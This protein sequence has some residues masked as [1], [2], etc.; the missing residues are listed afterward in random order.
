MSNKTSPWDA[1]W[2]ISSDKIFIINYLAYIY[3]DQYRRML[4]VPLQFSCSAVQMST[5]VFY[6]ICHVVYHIRK[7]AS[8]KFTG[9]SEIFSDFIFFPNSSLWELKCPVTLRTS[10]LHGCNFKDGLNSF[11]Q[12][13]RDRECLVYW[14]NAKNPALDAIGGLEGAM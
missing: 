6:H 12:P 10:K 13:P 9:K 5:E 11:F 3:V 14:H 7:D 8:P 1:F 4:A 2:Q